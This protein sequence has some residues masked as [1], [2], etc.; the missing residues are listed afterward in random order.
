MIG[1]RFRGAFSGIASPYGSSLRAAKVWPRRLECFLGLWP[2]GSGQC[3]LAVSSCAWLIGAMFSLGFRLRRPRPCRCSS[4]SCG[5]RVMRR[6]SFVIVGTLAI[7]GLVIYKHDGKSAAARR[8]GPSRAFLL[9]RRKKLNDEDR[10]SRRGRMGYGRW[11]SSFRAAVSRTRFRFGY[12][13]PKRCE[14]HPAASVKT[15]TYLPG[16]KL[17][18]S[19]RV[20]GE[21]EATFAGAQVIVGAVPSAYARATYT[22]ALPFVA[23][24]A[25]FRK[26]QQG[27]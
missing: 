26:H 17:P 11:R 3:T 10:H 13:M 20:H 2:A 14:I 25:S 27:T 9:A 19:V 6:Q 5:R 1:G 24:G 8:R 16:L 15:K 12:T 23:S 21:L 22:L 4:I 7:A 18:E